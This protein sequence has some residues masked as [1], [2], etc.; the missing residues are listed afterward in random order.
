MLTNYFKSAIRF[1][2]QNKVFAAVNASG[3]SIALAASF[4]ILLYVIN[5][6]SY[7]HCHKNRD[8]VYR[9]L[10]YYVDFKNTMSGT[11]Y[12]LASALKAEFPQIEKAVTTRPMRGFRLKVKDE[13][14]DV[15]NA[16]ATDSDV[17]DIFTIRL[18]GNASHMN[19]LDDKSS[20]VI[21][22]DLAR[23]IFPS[24]DPVG[25]EITGSV[26][27]VEQV[28]KVTGVYENIPENSTF[29]AQCL[30]SSRWT[31][32]EISKVF[33]TN[34][35]KDWTVNFWNNWV[36]VSKNC[37]IKSIENR[38]RAFEVKNI[39]EKPQFNYSLQNLS[40]VYL[41]SAHVSNSGIQ[42]NI[43]NIRL[44]SAIAL[45]I[46]LVAAINYIILS[47]AV[48]SARAKEIGVRKTYG[49]GTGSIKNQ[50]F[51]ES[52]M[53]SILVLP[54]ALILGWLAIPFAGKLFQT[55]LHIIKSNIPQ[56]ILIYT[57]ITIL[58]GIAAG[59]YTSG[60]LSN[61][62]VAGILKN[63]VNTG[64]K[65]SI[66]RSVLIIIE[67]VIFCSFV[68]ATLIIR[69][70]YKYAINKDPGYYN[71][72]ILL[73]SLGRDFKGYAAYINNIR[74]NPNIIS[75]G[76]VMYGLPMQ[77]SMS[78]MLPNFEDKTV[79]VNVEG[80]AVDYNFLK[81]M[82]VQFVAGRDFSQDYGSDLKESV[83]LN[84]TAIKK[85][86]IATPLEQKIG[87]QSIIGV[88]KDFNLHSIH[89]DI[90]PLS[91]TM[92]DTYIDHVAVHFKPGTLK[93]ILPFLESEWKK[94]APDR[95]FNFTTIEDIF[96]ELYSSEKNLTTIVS[97]FAL[98]TIVI[99][100]FGLFGLTLF[101]GKTRSR[102][103]GLKKV[104]GSSEKKI[105]YSF[106]L[107]NFILTAIAFLLSIPASY[108]FMS[109]WLTNFAY[110]VTIDPRIFVI[111]FA[112]AEIV[113]LATVYF[114]SY[115]ASRVNPVVALRYE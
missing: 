13:Y 4:I 95:P 55:Q 32:P 8:R 50:L 90:P 57:I 10:N 44:F 104:F 105:V 94:T 66:I 112:L 96:K 78:F 52:I 98:F 92:T 69:S 101:I 40:D 14:I 107:E 102:E 26:N 27:N 15:F 37:D 36:L 46:L 19:M 21:S 16:I 23:K 106:L 38:F 39:N 93:S 7:N 6:L 73:V 48:S 67:L 25:K 86:G 2:K 79:N 114:H 58:I 1:L 64:K 5:E 49:A 60:Y 65:K 56:Y 87:N 74:L 115:K 99:A 51:T 9:V 76:G 110:K 61:L 77:N 80:L 83:I 31:L 34:A 53:L 62:K 29:R 72:D 28:F 113:V 97:I 11:P 42:G 41:R 109:K 35:E 103:I 100:A 12:V 33:N 17:F 81:T 22:K 43:K 108:Y 68:S 71:K 24:G 89:S 63:A 18:V 3:L 30:I 111:T 54:N 20:L 85:L 88:V 84:E 75:A 70:Q 91:I 45:V 59:I 47:T 82:G